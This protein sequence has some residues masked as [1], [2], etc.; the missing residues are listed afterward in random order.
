MAPW[1]H[2]GA[3]GAAKALLPVAGGAGLFLAAG[4][5]VWSSLVASLDNYLSQHVSYGFQE[6]ISAHP[7]ITTKRQVSSMLVRS[8]DRSSGKRGSQ[9]GS[10][11]DKTVLFW[12]S[13]FGKSWWVRLGGG[14]DL[15]AAQCPETRCVFTHDRSTQ[16]EAAAVLFQSQGVD[17]QDFPR[18]R[19]W[20]QRWVWVHVEAPPASAAAYRRL[21]HRS[22]EEAAPRDLSSLFNWTMTYHPASDV[23]EPYG[24]ILPLSHRGEGRS[25]TSPAAPASSTPPGST[26]PPPH[27]SLSSHLRP[28]F[29]NPSS[30]PYVA[31]LSA[32]R[33]GKTL[34]RLLPLGW[35]H[36]VDRDVDRSGDSWEAFLQRPRLVAWMSSHCHT[37]SRREDYVRRLQLHVPVDIYG[38]CGPLR[39]SRR[40]EHRGDRCWRQVLGPKYLFYLAFENALCDAYVTEKL[41]R[42][43][44]HGLVPV[45]LGGANYT[46]ILPP[47]SY[48]DAVSLTPRQLGHLLRRLQKTP[49]EYAEYHLWRAFWRPTLRPPL[50]ELCLRLHGKVKRTTQET[51]QPGG[52]RRASAALRSGPGRESL[53]FALPPS[54]TH[55][56]CYCC[57]CCCSVPQQDAILPR[58]GVAAKMVRMYVYF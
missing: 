21:H 55:C 34:P 53:A 1:R 46:A 45:V 6:D 4:R 27:D 42:P 13:W 56:C 32:L 31:Y 2:H 5:G 10:K 48:I 22:L 23:L 44:V 24:A 25:T 15:G 12:T 33:L 14:M 57:C 37:A 54:L 43:L 36:Y 30:G 20:W 19:Q 40:E 3:G 47:N 28:T 41:W 29:L 7:S 58:T 39:C 51:W 17:V 49:Q 26:L 52:G 18:G 9:Q 8:M 35:S 16:H 50:C 11:D 38:A